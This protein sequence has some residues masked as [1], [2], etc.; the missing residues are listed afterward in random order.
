MELLNF[1]LGVGG[2]AG[3]VWV[4]CKSRY[5]TSDSARVQWGITLLGLMWILLVL[6]DTV[7]HLQPTEGT[8]LARVILLVALFLLKPLLLTTN[9]DT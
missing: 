3:W 1:L 2:F 6:A 4:W 5:Q 7:Q 8:V 9:K